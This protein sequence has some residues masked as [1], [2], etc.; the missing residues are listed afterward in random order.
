MNK[1]LRWL[2]VVVVLHVSCA[3]QEPSVP[4]P[5]PPQGASVEPVLE[6]LG[7]SVAKRILA[8]GYVSVGVRYDLQPFGFVT[9][10]GEVAGFDVDLG[11]ELAARWLG[12]AA[13]V[14]F[15]HVRSDSATVHLGS[16]DVDVAIAGL[17]HNQ[18][19]EA[20]VDFSFAYFNDGQALLVR[21][22]D[23]E[24]VTG[25]SD[26][27]GRPVGIVESN[28]AEEALSAVVPFTLTVRAYGRFDDAVA[29]LQD[30]EVN[31]VAD[32]R[33]R[34]FW[35]TRLLPGTLVVGQYTWEPVAV[36][37]REGDPFFSD[38]V[39]LT[40]QDIVR[41]GSYAEIYERWFPSDTPAAVPDWPGEESLSIGDSIPQSVVSGTIED[42][43][44]TGR[45][46]AA[47][48]L[49]VPPF[50]AQ[51]EAGQPTGYEV[52]LVQLMAERWLGEP[53]SVDFVPASVDDGHA[54]LE[55]GQAHILVGGLVHTRSGELRIDYSMHTH[56]AG[57]GARALGLPRGDA[58]FR[59]LVN[60][61]LQAMVAEGQVNALHTTW[62]GEP[63]SMETWPGENIR[64]LRLVLPAQTPED[65]G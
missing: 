55:A 25:P 47:V 43:Q 29:A 5:Q 58:G 17:T 35:G 65:I 28:G 52:A 12:D 27:Q 39:N 7:E 21:A 19:L 1:S 50:T 24:V 15:R 49:D 53:G 10:D 36:A 9:D 48:V 11:T 26:L 32:K 56:V 6:T 59:D 14:R 40:L 30:G 41:D 44:S 4:D 37:Y 18:E 63:P 61:T 42:I 54:L 3:L 8:R 64:D 2:P 13:A 33:R 22:G 45:L 23:A 46:K 31:A 38:L 51:D 20:G 62:F 57:E 16:G 60:L 34:L